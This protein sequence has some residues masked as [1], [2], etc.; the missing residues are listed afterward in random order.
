MVSRGRTIVLAFC[1]V[2]GLAACKTEDTEKADACGGAGLGTLVGAP[3]SEFDADA[4]D[5][6]VR[7]LPPDSAMTM[8]HR[9]DRLNIDKDGTGTVTRVWCG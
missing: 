2:A 6:P 8:D 4:W 1:A 9:P 3:V 5:G 7:I